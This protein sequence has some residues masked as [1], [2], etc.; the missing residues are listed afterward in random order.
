M[1][2]YFLRLTIFLSATI[3]IFS[4]AAAQDPREI[5]RKVED[6]MR[7]DASYTEMTMTTVRPRYTREISMRSWSL[8]D[9]FALIMITAPA[10]DQGTAFLKREKEIWNFV[11]S[12]D[13]TVKM[14]PSMMSQSWMGS[15]FTN[16]D[17]V[18]GSS[19]IDDFTH[20]LL[21]SETMNGHDCRVLELKPKPEAPVV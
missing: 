9:D 4:E 11:P 12:I 14:P 15:D 19:T 20:R 21:R 13:R 18:R 6:N 3:L 16:D 7:G 2:T 17:L 10:R 5:L 8:G 1:R